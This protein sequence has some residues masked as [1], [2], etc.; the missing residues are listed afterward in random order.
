[1]KVRD[2]VIIKWNERYRALW[3]FARVDRLIPVKDGVVRAVQLRAEKSYLERAVQHL[4]P[5]ELQCDRR[6]NPV[7]AE[8][9]LYRTHATSLSK[10]TAAAIVDITMK[11]QFTDGNDTLELE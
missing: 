8:E 5:L 9:W 3:M 10:R 7:L 1:M 11:D 2:V 6:D 4:Y